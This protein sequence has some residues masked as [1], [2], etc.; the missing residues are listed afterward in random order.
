MSR[1]VVLGG[2]IGFV[3]TVLFMVVC[4]K[5]QPP[6]PVPGVTR[7]EHLEPVKFDE[8]V[9]ALPAAVL[10]HR[11]AGS[12]PSVVRPINLEFWDAGRR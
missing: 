7:V 3:L 2:V 12:L 6:P 11:P 5:N 4:Q 9:K 1:Q 10:R 8:P